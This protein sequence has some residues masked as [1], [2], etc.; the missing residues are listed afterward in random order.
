[1]CHV[2]K[3]ITIQTQMQEIGF[4]RFIQTEGADQQKIAKTK[5]RALRC[6]GPL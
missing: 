3:Y 5:P 6:A 2:Y 1:M 4:R